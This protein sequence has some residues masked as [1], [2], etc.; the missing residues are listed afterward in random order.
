MPAVQVRDF[1]Q[2]TYDQIKREAKESGR[3]IM[4]QTK[5]IVV[6]HFAQQGNGALVAGSSTTLPAFAAH[7]TS[8]TAHALAHPAGQNPFFDGGIHAVQQR[9]ARREA[10]FSRIASREYPAA[11]RELDS[12]QLVR[13]LRDER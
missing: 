2:E 1:S 4:Q 10:L 6:Q 5:H 7:E 9:Q 12:E 3:S 13:Q 8:A 11:A